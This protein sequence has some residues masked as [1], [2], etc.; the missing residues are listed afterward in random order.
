[1]MKKYHWEF[2]EQ[3]QMCSVVRDSSERRLKNKCEY[4]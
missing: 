4:N 3:I 1:M 2:Y